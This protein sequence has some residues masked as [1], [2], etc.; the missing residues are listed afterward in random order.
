MQIYQKFYYQYLLI[1]NAVHLQRQIDT[2]RIIHIIFVQLPAITNLQLEE[3]VYLW[4]TSAR[5][6]APQAH[7]GAIINYSKIF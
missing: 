4:L 5:H 2:D 1:F 3:H 7:F 6:G